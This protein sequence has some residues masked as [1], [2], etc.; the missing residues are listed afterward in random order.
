M[1]ICFYGAVFALFASVGALA[2]LLATTSLS[3]IQIISVVLI[4]GGFA[5]GYARVSI[6]QRYWLI[7]V[8][9]V[10]EGLLFAVVGSSYHAAP[11][12]IATDSPLHRQI[13]ILATIGIASV[14]IGYILFAVFFARQGARYFRAHNE[15]AMA[16]E[17]HRSLVPPIHRSI[18]AFEIYAISVP[19]GEVGGDLVDV[20]EDGPFWTGYVADVSGHGVSAGLMMAM[21]KT[22]VRT[23]PSGLSSGELLGDVHRALYPLKT[24]NMFATAGVLQ[25]T[26][27]HFSLALAGHPPLLHYSRSRGDVQE[28]APLDLP[29]GVLPQ[30]TFR[31]EQIQCDSGDLLLLLTDG[32]TE[33]FDKHGREMGLHPI[34]EAFKHSANQTLPDICAILRKTALTFGKQDDDQTMLLVRCL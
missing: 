3:L 26:G 6:A 1:R 28:F 29:V 34:K 17:I 20:A 32:L 8:I 31:S 19:S 5:V 12:L 11:Q 2:L 4:T 33:V 7:P 24:P 23:S 13:D 27:E 21:F 25:W 9:G 30:Q 14:W 10:I 15:I 18:G 22:A 16:S